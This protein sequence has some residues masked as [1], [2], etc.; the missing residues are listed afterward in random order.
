[1]S[2]PGDDSFVEQVMRGIE[3]QRRL[4]PVTV[5]ALL[6]GVLV[7]SLPAL[8]VLRARGVLMAFAALA[9]AAAGEAVSATLDNV[10]FWS[11]VGIAALWLA[12]L[13]IRWARAER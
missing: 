5:L 6:L 12:W 11:A 8:V 4:L 7:L 3:R 9:G 10:V 2:R 13:G 1:M